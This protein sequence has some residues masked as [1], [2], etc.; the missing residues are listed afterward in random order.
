VLGGLL[1]LDPSAATGTDVTALATAARDVL[2]RAPSTLGRLA[3]AGYQRIVY[4]GSGPLTSLA[5]ES[6]LKVLELTAGRVM[7]YFDSPLGFRHGPKAM[8]RPGT[9]AVVYVSN[10]PY[11]RQY[12]EDIVRELR[13]ALGAEHVVVL[14]AH[15]DPMQDADPGRW[16]LPGLEEAQDVALALPYLVVAQLL[17]L[18]T[19][20]ALGCTPDD[21]FPTGEVNRVVQGVTVYPLGV[22]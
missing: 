2:D 5:R 4:L 16:V 17:A 18:Q 8:L 10:D 12:D 21:P 14:T 20:I 6:A 9:L 1:A 3:S 7:S 19:S 11:T 13:A 15:V 22:S